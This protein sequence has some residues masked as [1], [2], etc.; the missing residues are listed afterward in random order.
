MTNEN[1]N[2]VGATAH[3]MTVVGNPRD[4]LYEFEGMTSALQ[5]RLASFKSEVDVAIVSGREP[6]SRELRTINGAH[7]SGMYISDVLKGTHHAGR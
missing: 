6:T 1:H 5:A 7:D 3:G 2:A 4:V